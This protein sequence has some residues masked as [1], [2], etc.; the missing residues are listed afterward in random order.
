MRLKI[1][2][3]TLFIFISIHA[4]VNWIPITVSDIVT[5]VPKGID[6]PDDY[7]QG[8]D[9]NRWYVYANNQNNALSKV[10]DSTL[11][12]NVVSLKTSNGKSIAMQLGNQWNDSK[13]VISW[14]QKIKGKCKIYIK[15]NTTKGKRYIMYQSNIQDRG[16]YNGNYLN[17][18]LPAYENNSWTTITR[19]IDSDLKR[20][21]SDNTFIS[22][23]TFLVRVYDE[24]RFGSIILNEPNSRDLLNILFSKL[25]HGVKLS[26]IV[27]KDR[28]FINHSSSPLF[29]IFI[30]DSNNNEKS[31]NSNSGWEEVIISSNP[32]RK[33]VTLKHP[34]DSFFP[35][36]LT[37]TITVDIHDKKSAWDIK[38]DGIGNSH[39]LM[40]VTFPT[41]DI[42]VDGNSKFFT[43]FRYGQLHKVSS[44]FRYGQHINNEYNGGAPLGL[45]PAGW[46][47]T[48]QY[49][50][51]YN[52]SYGL[53]F[54]FH[55][56]KASLK[57]MVAH[58]TNG[59]VEISCDTPVP[60]MT[61]KGNSFDF[62]GHF[63]LDLFKGNWYEASQIYKDWVFKYADY[64]PANKLTRAREKL[65]N[66]SV[67]GVEDLYA[68][69]QKSGNSKE[70][71]ANYMENIKNA[72]GDVGFGSYY[73]TA[74]YQEEYGNKYNNEYDFP[75]FYPSNDTKYMVNRLNR[76]GSST[77]IYT[78]AYLYNL[79]IDSPDN[80]VP[81]FDVVRSDAVKKKD[82]SIYS[83][84]W[85]P[86]G[87]N[88]KD[89]AIMCPIGNTWQ[90]ILKNV[91]TQKLKPL[92]AD[93]FLLDQVTA[94]TPV[95]CFDENHHHTLG[96]GHYW[97]DGYK[98]LINKLHSVHGDNTY[99]VS[100]AVNDSLMDVI[101]GYQTT[102]ERFV[103]KD[104]V[105]AIQTIYGGKIQFIGGETGVPA[106][107]HNDFYPIVAQSFVFGNIL[108]FYYPN[109]TLNENRASMGYLRKLAM[110]RE[111]L[112]EFIGFG[113][114]QKQLHTLPI[115][116]ATIP[117]VQM[118]RAGKIVDILAIQTGSWRDKNGNLVI[119]FINANAPKSGTLSFKTNFSLSLYGLGNEVSIRELKDDGS[120][121]DIGIFPDTI[122]LKGS[123]IRAFIISK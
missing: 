31:I 61:K 65:A 8:G 34:T 22:V 84:K 70:R 37:V 27:Y 115:Q 23:D 114:M 49:M 14:E 69:I 106:Y 85:P 54:G 30:G 96:G 67:W 102:H 92:N 3:I 81:E 50:A 15:I 71:E 13:S 86:K 10:Y 48:M 6:S 83:Q 58:S 109:L 68:D 42:K 43:P 62:P 104:A 76:F 18:G 44:N 28:E 91:H 79:H 16:L 39:S 38:V 101:D 95:M 87:P 59:G 93:G 105:P 89:N 116:N 107:S 29:N 7:N 36:M 41:I 108:G 82:S 19:D 60:N 100:E 35:S 103:Y 25:N 47:A 56:K 24:G 72:L 119:V 17:I 88:P 121:R 57:N 117:T 75:K 66:I 26:N 40:Y 55:D 5:F 94:S 2:F 112:K 123:E 90:D 51:Y 73:L 97:R 63:E 12:K 98:E 9:I 118:K 99:L 33:I 46:K 122:K 11:K 111:R 64:K 80:L 21:E 74:H 20:V 113:V 110:M 1:L 52:S 77:M 4:K 45:Y 53:Y 78:N 120:S 32:K